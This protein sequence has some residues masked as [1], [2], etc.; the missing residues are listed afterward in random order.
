MAIFKKVAF[1]EVYVFTTILNNKRSKNID[2][3]ETIDLDTE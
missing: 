3:L 1:S 2:Q